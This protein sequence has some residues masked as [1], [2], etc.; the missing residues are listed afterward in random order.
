MTKL[1][2]NP[3]DIG[4]VLPVALTQLYFDS[5]EFWPA[6]QAHGISY[7]CAFEDKPEKIAKMAPDI[8]ISLMDLPNDPV[9]GTS[10]KFQRQIYVTR[11]IVAAPSLLG[12][13]YVLTPSDLEKLSYAT[14]SR[15]DL[16]PVS[17]TS[18]CGQ[19]ATVMPQR[20]FKGNDLF[21]AYEAAKQGI[22]FAIL[23][24]WM[25]IEDIAQGHLMT[26]LPDWRPQY[27]SIQ[28]R[29]SQNC[30]NTQHAYVLRDLLIE[31][32]RTIP[33]IDVPE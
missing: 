31:K 7:A 4:V 8:Q 29:I 19:H 16:K 30:Q 1:A 6:S 9:D 11:R 3:T 12:E 15:N 20:Y 21:A 32:L 27:K 18:K 25:V 17:L 24:E 13:A 26:L 10:G 28:I 2:P 5:L 14:L 22:S 33:G 23:P